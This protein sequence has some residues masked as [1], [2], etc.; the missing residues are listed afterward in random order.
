MFVRDLIVLLACLI[1]VAIIL[2]A[3]CVKANMMADDGA[4]I[5]GAYELASSGGGTI[6]GGAANIPGVQR[7][8]LLNARRIGGVRKY[9]SY[10]ANANDMLVSSVDHNAAPLPVNRML[11]NRPNMSHPQVTDAAGFKGFINRI[12]GVNHTDF[13][14]AGT[15]RGPFSTTTRGTCAYNTDPGDGS[16]LPLQ[17]FLYQPPALA[18][19]GG[20]L[21]FI[22]SYQNGRMMRNKW[23]QNV[24][25]PWRFFKRS[26]SIFK[27]SFWNIK[28][29]TDPPKLT[30][31]DIS[32]YL[33]RVRVRGGGILNHYAT[34]HGG[35]PA[36]VPP[37]IPNLDYDND[38]DILEESGDDEEPDD[39]DINEYKQSDIA[40]YKNTYGQ[41][42]T[43]SALAKKL[44]RAPSIRSVIS[45]PRAIND[46]VHLMLYFMERNLMAQPNRRWETDL[47]YRR[48]FFH[49][50]LTKNPNWTHMP[51]K[52]YWQYLD[53]VGPINM[54][55]PKMYID[56]MDKFKPS[57]VLDTDAANGAC[58]VACSY[59]KTRPDYYGLNPILSNQMM[60]QMMASHLGDEKY[61]II[62]GSIDSHILPSDFPLSFVFGD[63]SER[64]IEK[65]ARVS[66][67]VVCINCESPIPGLK[68]GATHKYNNNYVAT[69][70]SR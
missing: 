47:D 66:R 43:V 69:Y 27:G 13:I 10:R 11:F 32:K 37:V 36:V 20:H 8:A 21:Y 46:P 56:A 44:H 48:E 5:S 58:I 19:A 16:A 33:F 23:L 62:H 60:L 42:E 7:F 6:T 63:Q 35:A 3:A 55:P 38:D 24:H 50:A 26:D 65:V 39:D 68:K 41:H 15:N 18:A 2:C 17:M 28:D 12:N 25:T 49:S 54:A 67:V 9:V 64:A 14:F 61:N 70:W 29:R 34:G 1:L 51:D 4:L 57:L 52:Y 40:R 30:N 31:A 53:Y 22:C 59:A 45:D